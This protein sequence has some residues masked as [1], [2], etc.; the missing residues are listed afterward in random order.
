MTIKF[1]KLVTNEEIVADVSIN[2]KG[3]FVL[4]E[5]VTIRVYPSQIAGGQPSLGFGPWPTFGDFSKPI[6]V[7]V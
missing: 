6:Q 7:E 1:L 5:P 4:R 2:S 3:Q